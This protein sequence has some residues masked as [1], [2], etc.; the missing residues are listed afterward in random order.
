MIQLTIRVNRILQSVNTALI[1]DEAYKPEARKR[2]PITA[3][4]PRIWRRYPKKKWNNLQLPVLTSVPQGRLGNAMGEYATLL[5]LGRVYGA[6]VRLHPKMENQLKDTFPNITMKPIP[7]EVVGH[8]EVCCCYITYNDRDWIRLPA[9]S[10]IHHG[11]AEA[12]ASGLLGPNLFVTEYPFGIHL[13]NTFPEDVRREFTFSPDIQRQV[14]TFWEENSN[15]LTKVTIG[16]HV[17]RTDYMHALLV[18]EV[19]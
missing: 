2:L 11:M 7:G 6:T 10:H 1:D 14:R 16:V 15:Y 9:R 5:A 12:A 13:F 19:M 8:I 3:I 17:R 4:S 18:T